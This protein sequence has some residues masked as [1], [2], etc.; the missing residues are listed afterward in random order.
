MKKFSILLGACAL[1]A[2]CSP[3]RPD[4]VEN[5]D[6]LA[7]NAASTLDL[8][9]VVASDSA[10]VLSFDVT[11]TP[12]LWIRIAETSYIIADGDTLPLLSASGIEPGAQF[13]MP[14]SGRAAFDLTFGPIGPKVQKI[15]FSEGDGGWTLVGIDLMGNARTEPDVPAK[16]LR[17][18]DGEV[19][20]QPIQEV[21]D[22]EFKLH[23]IDYV[24]ELG[25]KV[26]AR[27]A[28]LGGSSFEETLKLDADGSVT[29]SAPV[30]GTSDLYIGL[31]DMNYWASPIVIAPEKSIEVYLDPRFTMSAS[32]ARLGR[33]DNDRY[34]YDNGRYAALNAQ[35]AATDFDF[36]FNMANEAVAGLWRLTPAQYTDSVLAMS[37]TKAVEIDN[38]LADRQ[39]KA[40]LKAELTDRALTSILTAQYAYIRSFYGEYPTFGDNWRDSIPEVPGKAEYVRAAKA[41]DIAAPEML[42]IPGYRFLVTDVDLS[43][44]GI[45]DR[46]VAEVAAYA[47]AYEQTDAGQLTE[48]T[49][50]NL[51]KLSTPFY[52]NAIEARAAEVQKQAE[53]LAELI[54]ELPDVD[55]SELFAAIMEQYKGKVVLVDLW[56]TWCGPCRRALAA[57]EPLKAGELS[58]PDIVWVYIA[59]TS[60][61]LG[62]YSAMIPNIAGE[63][64]M[65]NAEQIATIRSQFSV[66]GIPYYILVDREGNAVGH[67]DFRDHSLLIEGIKSKL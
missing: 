19:Y 36:G 57:N 54:H 49:I 43:A 38:L 28:G 6:V 34:V 41:L 50:D 26:S 44:N 12:G 40:Y 48:Q 3:Q 15:T 60:S 8:T 53:A 29:F 32:N 16:I 25:T 30:Y 17:A 45:A 11:F 62:T 21:A 66:D 56:N 24:P 23:I 7:S 46:Q 14:E 51:R 39:F 2:A 59:D 9:K 5:P 35:L 31:A 67:P 42:M 18:A 22:T 1:L 20:A 52:A 65:V 47:N 13:T 4:Q 58:D 64:Y 10:T 27:I 63:H 61:N 37:Q 55:D 33:E